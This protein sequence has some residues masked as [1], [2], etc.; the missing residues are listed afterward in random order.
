M[1]RR[2]GGIGR[3][4]LGLAALGLLAVGG[5]RSDVGAIVAVDGD[6]VTAQLGLL[7]ARV[8]ELVRFQVQPQRRHAEGRA[9]VTDVDPYTRRV[10]LVLLMET[11]SR[12]S[13]ATR[14]ATPPA[15]DGKAAKPR[16]DPRRPLV[17]AGDVITTQPTGR[18][19]LKVPD[20]LLPR[21]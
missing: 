6:H 20:F 8:G 19:L 21:P 4:T 11:P 3:M 9:V 13:R 1:K 5:A 12:R 10:A 17:V 7:D 15:K 2:L 14:K 18:F 16:F